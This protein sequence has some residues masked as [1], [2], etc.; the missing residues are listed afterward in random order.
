MGI[1]TRVRFDPHIRLPAL[2]ERVRQM[3]PSGNI[4]PTE[5]ATSLENRAAFE[6]FATRDDVPGLLAVREVKFLISGYEQGAPTLHFM[7]STRNPLHFDFAR[8][9]LG[10]AHDA[11]TFNRVTYFSQD[12]QFLAG[13]VLAYDN[14]MLPDGSQG[15]YALEFWPTDP[16]ST[17]YVAQAFQMVEDGMAFAQGTLAYHPS[18]DVQEQ[19]LIRDAE[20]FASHSVRTISTTELFD[21]IEYNPLNLG[22]A[23]GILRLM[24]GDDPRPPSATDI[25]IYET[26]PN[27]LPLVAGVISAAPQTPLSHVNLRAQQNGIANAYLRNA[28]QNPLLNEHIGKPIRLMVTAD[29]L[30]IASVTTAEMLASLESRRPANIQTL[31]RNLGPREIVSLDDLAWTQ[32]DAFGAKATN[33][34]ELR[35]AI[36]PKYVPNG[37]AVPFSFYHDFMVANGL[38][39]ALRVMMNDSSFQDDEHRKDLLQT[40]QTKSGRLLRR[41]HR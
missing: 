41:P 20:E 5:G 14:F 26:L 19:L 10:Y 17:S 30:E 36:D 22:E 39:D 27:D 31:P 6:D 24:T 13:T 12:R 7:N 11:A 35:R 25:V 15:L 3:R 34:A 28:A 18:G 16:V 9:H 4:S 33:V 29:R 37:F 21:G 38:Y 8:D 32:A 2:P 23:I 1:G 40:V